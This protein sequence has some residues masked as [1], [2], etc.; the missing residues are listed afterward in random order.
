MS[1]TRI[2][3][4]L[5]LPS[6]RCASL[7]KNDSI[8]QTSPRQEEKTR[9]IPDNQD[10]LIALPKEVKAL[11]EAISL[12]NYAELRAVPKKTAEGKIIGIPTKSAIQQLI[13]IFSTK[14]NANIL[15]YFHSKKYSAKECTTIISLANSLLLFREK[16]Q[17][18]ENNYF[19]AREKNKSKGETLASL[20]PRSKWVER[21]HFMIEQ[22][23]GL[24]ELAE[25]SPTKYG[26]CIKNMKKL[27]ENTY[28]FI[29][30]H[31]PE[32]S[33]V[34]STFKP[35]E[36]AP[37]P[38]KKENI[39]ENQPVGKKGCYRTLFNKPESTATLTE[40]NWL[41]QKHRKIELNQ[42]KAPKDKTLK[43]KRALFQSKKNS[44]ST[45]K[46]SSPRQ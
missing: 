44:S 16:I 9:L 28:Q 27:L 24:P 22:H 20:Y 4:T 32:K 42:S 35:V 31:A 30:Q 11:A 41:I 15:H 7:I 19:I 8:S 37:S 14:Q 18:A 39:A 38:D 23:L 1:D 10:T 6:T 12:F 40:S 29:K 2:L 26:N 17:E 46:N 5:A 33:S 36:S 25:I 13:S 34:Y 43:R 21:F 45:S 3:Q